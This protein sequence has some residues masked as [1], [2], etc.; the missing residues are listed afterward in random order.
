M[1]KEGPPT[2]KQKQLVRKISAKLG[3]KI[4]TMPENRLKTSQLISQ[5]IKMQ[6]TGRKLISSTEAQRLKFDSQFVR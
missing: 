2:S 6:K 5:L 1:W 3:C 4:T